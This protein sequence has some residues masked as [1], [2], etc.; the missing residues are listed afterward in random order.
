MAYVTSNI[1][2]LEHA[3]WHHLLAYFACMAQKHTMRYPNQQ[4][5]Y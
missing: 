2:E 5:K 3:C 1:Y 4:P